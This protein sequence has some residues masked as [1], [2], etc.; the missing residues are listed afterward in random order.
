MWL[1][2]RGEAQHVFFS[3]KVEVM[4]LDL[5]LL[6]ISGQYKSVEAPAELIIC[7]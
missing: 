2:V 7:E 5:W 6:P 3:K 4:H 1:I